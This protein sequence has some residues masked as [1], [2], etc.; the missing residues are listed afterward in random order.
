MPCLQ[1]VE[2]QGEPLGTPSYHAVQSLAF[3]HFVLL[4]GGPAFSPLPCFR[5][6]LLGDLPL[7]VG[8]GSGKQCRALL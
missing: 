1:L 8:K 7:D 6:L 2:P 4:F 3:R 5:P